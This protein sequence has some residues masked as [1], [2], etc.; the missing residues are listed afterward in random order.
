MNPSSPKPVFSD[1]AAR[2]RAGRHGLALFLG[3]LAM[4]F[5]ASILGVLII[6]WRSPRWSDLE[7]PPPPALLW[8]STGLLILS[9]GTMQAAIAMLRRS[10]PALL[11]AALIVTMLL[12]VGFLV[13]QAR[14]WLV[15]GPAAAESMRRSDDAPALA[16]AGFFILTGLHAVHVLGGLVPL[17]VVSA[18]AARGRLSADRPG[19]APFVALYWHFLDGVWL[20]LFLTLLLA[21]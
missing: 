6:R 13:L 19:W 10:R 4:L 15:W 1:P 18:A 17:V 12:G 20:V 11:A 7:L 8:V 3:S 14:C 16:L 21:V 5:A 2:Y 9:S